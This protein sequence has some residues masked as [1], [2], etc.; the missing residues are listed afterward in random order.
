MAAVDESHYMTLLV[1][2]SVEGL[3]AHGSKQDADKLYNLFNSGEGIKQF[4]KNL[5]ALNALDNRNAA[6]PNNKQPP[7]KVEQAF[8]LTL[9]QNGI[10]VPLKFLLA[11][12]K[13]FKPSTPAK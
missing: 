11:I 13:D 1:K 10:T 6:D 7:Y 3:E 5:E 2:G 9:K 4:I 12:N 8:A